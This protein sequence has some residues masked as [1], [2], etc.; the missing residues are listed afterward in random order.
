MVKKIIKSFVK[1]ISKNA[2][3]ILLGLLIPIILFHICIIIKI[4]PYHIIWG[5]KLQNDT[6]MFLFETIST[7]INSLLG[8]ILLMKANFVSYKF[9]PWIITILLG[10]FLAVFILNTVGNIFAETT[11]EKYLA[12]LTAIFAILLGKI[13]VQ[14]E[15]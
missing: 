5:G 1:F 11:F 10:I 12:I 8:W 6:E 15:N 4:I 13:I 9:S 7:L 14:K 2:I 3:K